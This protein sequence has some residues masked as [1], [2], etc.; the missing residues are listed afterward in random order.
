MTNPLVALNKM[1]NL[2]TKEVVSGTMASLTYVTWMVFI[3]FC[4]KKAEPGRKNKSRFDKVIEE[5]SADG[6]VA[7]P[8]K[9]YQRTVKDGE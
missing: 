7:L 1:L 9:S 2:S 4:F 6:K 5:A 3:A 8:D